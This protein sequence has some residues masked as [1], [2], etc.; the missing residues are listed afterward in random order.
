MLAPA[1]N[2]RAM[3]TLTDVTEALNRVFGEEQDKH[4]AHRRAAPI[5]E[6]ASREPSF[7]TGV[8]EKH[9]A[10]PGSLEALN[11]PVVS[12]KPASTPFFEL[13]V[14]CW[15]PLPSADTHVT[16][17]A[18]HHHGTLLLTTATIF[19]I[20]YEHM[21]FSP[22]AP[23]DKGKD[24]FS[25]K[26]TE[27]EL[28]PLHHVAFVDKWVPH[29]PLY[30]PS[31]TIT[32]ALWS[33]SARSTWKDR[34]KRV[35]VIKKNE[36]LLRAAVKRLGLTKRLDLKVIEYFDYFPVP[37]AEGTGFRGMRERQEFALGPNEHHLKS[38]FH[39]LQQTDNA[40][41][42]PLARRSLAACAAST[43]ALGE[44]LV[45]ALEKG[46]PIHGHLSE[47]HFGIPFANFTK[48]EILRAASGPQVPRMVETEHGR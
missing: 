4:A 22:A 1:P 36:K 45:D 18:I 30:P 14:N 21:L 29:V 46:R 7:L 35:P 47:G 15:I 39:T 44:P 10:E 27:S 13:A 37:A 24:L 9:L 12:L 33:G 43:R 38:F 5:L 19:G 16:T 42:A 3:K 2:A 25:M 28:H 20:G 11:Y 26:L 31:L 8:F 6:Q 40:Q 41:L 17:K 23:V 48:Q 32:L 34:V